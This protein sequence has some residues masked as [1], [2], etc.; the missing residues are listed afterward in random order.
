V[1]GGS[2]GRKAWE[3][4]GGR[5]EGLK[6]ERPAVGLPLSDQPVTLQGI[7]EQAPRNAASD[8]IP[9]VGVADTLAEFCDGLWFV[10]ARHW[11]T[12]WRVMPRRDAMARWEWPQRFSILT[13]R[14]WDMVSRSTTATIARRKKATL[15]M[16]ARERENI[17]R[18]G[19]VQERHNGRG[20]CNR[21]GWRRPCGAVLRLRSVSAD[22]QRDANR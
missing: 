6:G 14:L 10:H 16:A 12:R 9:T 1:L 18:G 4:E 19:I 11:R 2:V 3:G 7:N 15:K 13:R 20:W 17:I 8:G 21:D 22:G 5:G